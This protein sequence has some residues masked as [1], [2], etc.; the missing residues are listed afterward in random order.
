MRKVRMLQINVTDVARAKSFYCGLLGFKCKEEYDDILVLEH[1]G[2]DLVIHRVSRPASIAY[3]DACQTLLVFETRNIDDEVA[4]LKEKGVEFIQQ[5]P[6]TATP[7][8]YIGFRDPFGNV[9]ELLE[10]TP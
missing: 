7:G 1:E 9:H 2:P 10:P 3:P 4:R 8:R 5:A 6:V